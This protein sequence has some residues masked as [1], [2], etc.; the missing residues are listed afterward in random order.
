MAAGGRALRARSRGGAADPRQPGVIADAVRRLALAGIVRIEVAAGDTIYLVPDEKRP[1]LD[2]HRNAVIHRFIAPALLAAAM[3]LDGGE[4]PLLVVRQRALWLSRLLKLEFMYR[5]GTAPDEAFQQN[6]AFLVAVGALVREGDRLRPG[7]EPDLLAFLAEFPRAYLEAYQLAAATALSVLSPPDGTP[8][9][10]PD[11]RALVREAL[12]RGR[13][14]FLSGQIQLRES[15]SKATLE[16]AVEWLVTQGTMIED[17]GKL[18]LVEPDGRSLRAI[19]D[20]ITPH[21]RA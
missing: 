7:P 11:R 19:V 2:Y 9:A 18:R 12:E 5:V 10:T 13:A 4:V 16:N 15:L 21:S 6:L 17:E 20:G 1:V 14:A 3:G 8:A